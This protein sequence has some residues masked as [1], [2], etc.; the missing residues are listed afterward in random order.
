MNTPESL[1]L[2]KPHLSEKSTDLK[3]Q[4]QYVFDIESKA[5][6]NTVKKTIENYYHVKVIK[7]RT[8]RTPAKSK[9]WMGKTSYSQDK[10]KAIVTIQ[11]G[12]K[13]EL[14]V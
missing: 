2:K 1:I 6:K 8:I 11:E 4:N 3:S 12:Q 5:N 13:I 14:G 9:K 7:V 10:K